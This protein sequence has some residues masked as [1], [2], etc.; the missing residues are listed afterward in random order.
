MVYGGISTFSQ[1]LELGVTIG[2][3]MGTYL[4]TRH[5]ER[6][7]LFF[8]LMNVS[9]ASLMALQEKHILM[10]ATV[11]FFAIRYLWLSASAETQSCHLIIQCDIE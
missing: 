9:M 10:D 3:L 11:D 7:Y 8:M 4:M 6:G 1:A 5:D 2:F